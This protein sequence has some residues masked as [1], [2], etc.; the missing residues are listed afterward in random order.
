MLSSRTSTVC[1]VSYTHLDVYKRQIVAFAQQDGHNYGLVIL[2][3]D[4]PE[5]LFT[6]CDDLFDWALSLIHI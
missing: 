1:A 2:G 3:C 5:H 4:T 6:A